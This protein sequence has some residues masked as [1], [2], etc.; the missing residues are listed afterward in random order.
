MGNRA[1]LPRQSARGSVTEDSM[2][3]DRAK[4]NILLVENCYNN[5]GLIRQSLEAS[6]THCRLQTVGVGSDA[7]S[8]LRR[9]EPYADA[10]TPDLVMF[11]VSDIRQESFDLLDRIKADKMVGGVPVVL[12]IDAGSEKALDKLVNGRQEQTMFSPIDLDSFLK[13]MNSIRLDRFLSAVTLI[14]SLGFVLVTL[15]KDRSAQKTKRAAP[16]KP[17]PGTEALRVQTAW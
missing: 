9:D 10:P 3:V 7:L 5:V 2:T 15:P 11:D 4:T 1:P 16:A 13:A 8:Y 6:N 17:R 14:E 12:L